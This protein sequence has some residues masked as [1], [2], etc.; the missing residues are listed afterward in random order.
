MG[1][2]YRAFDRIGKRP[3]A[4]K[5]LRRQEAEDLVRFSREAAVLSELADPSVVQ[6]L[7][8]GRT[9]RGEAYIAMEW[10][11]GEPLRSA[12]DRELFAPETAV[13]IVRRVAAALAVAHRRGIV[14]RDLKPSNVFLVESSIER[15]K[16]LDFGIARHV[17]DTGNLTGTG[18]LVGT[19]CYMAPEQIHGSTIDVRA[20]VFALGCVLYECLSGRRA[21]SAKDPAAVLA[22]VLVED[23]PD[24]RQVRAGVSSSLAN[25]VTQMLSKEPE[26][27]PADAEAVVRALD[28]LPSLAS[29][30]DRPSMPSLTRAERR[31]TWV[32]V[33]GTPPKDLDET[34]TAAKGGRFPSLQPVMDAYGG[35][36]DVAHQDFIVAS[37]SGRGAPLDL[38][39]RAARCSL[40]L[41]TLLR[42]MPLS[43]ACGVGIP[44]HT[45]PSSD[46]LERAFAGLGPIRRGAIRLDM[47][48]TRLLGEHFELHTDESGIYLARERDPLDI[49][50]NLL[51][52]GRETPFVGRDRELATLEAVFEESVSERVARAVL[53][54]GDPGVGKSRLSYELLRR[55]DRRDDPIAV[56]L[57]HG[58]SVTTITPYGLVV[59]AI[60]R[61]AGMLE[62]GHPE[63]R[64]NQ[65]RRRLSTT[66]PNERSRFDRIAQFLGEIAGVPEPDATARPEVRQARGDSAR[67][68][69]GVCD[70]FIDW[71]RSECESHPVVFVLENL[72]WGDR[73]TLALV[74]TA[75]FALRDHPFMVL[76]LGRP[77]VRKRFGGLWV[78]RDVLELRLG[79]LTRRAS[80][81]LLDALLGGRTP[82]AAGIVER[83]DGNPYYLEELARAVCEE[84][85]GEVPDTVVG[86]AQARLDAVSPD[87]RRL[88]RAASVYGRRFSKGGVAALLGGPDLSQQLDGLLDELE[89]N[90]IVVRCRHAAFPGEVDYEF[91][92]T[93]IRDAAYALLTDDD[94][95][96]GHGL[97]AAWLLSQ[98]EPDWNVVAEHYARSGQRVDS[99]RPHPLGDWP[100]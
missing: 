17:E 28:E 46:V 33:A 83:A 12:L 15:V 26:E 56:F 86:M 95:K 40:A 80:G 57:A 19:W 72:Q 79:Q 47:T 10:L 89:C 99:Q 42:G 44:G 74:D 49:V 7:G 58:D 88:L 70:A 77:E 73:Q 76:A 65:L 92:Q 27:R 96:L 24:L 94:Q 41:Q 67:M 98:G 85:S 30:G 4:L 97:A 39:I 64:R 38:G 45:S 11:D 55:I 29:S 5:M 62:G 23:P 53:I 43:L 16:L 35:K 87:A 61:S 13:A 31:M 25:L 82:D 6:Y 14:H 91:R 93:M 37:F 21:F 18:T 36:L 48:S 8:H 51:F 59:G 1:T 50:R 66:I 75:L 84:Q 2:V 32:L 3:V 22:K 68:R 100:E 63:R 9:H 90:E 81:K 52:L 34:A 20:D 60:R 71:M 54:S 78:G 69:D